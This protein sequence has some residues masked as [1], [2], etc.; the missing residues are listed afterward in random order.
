M[1]AMLEELGRKESGLGVTGIV[2]YARND[3]P[4]WIMPIFE[5]NSFFWD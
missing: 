1:K 3:T 4:N 2:L 5:L